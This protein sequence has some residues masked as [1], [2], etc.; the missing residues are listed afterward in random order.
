MTMTS[1]EFCGFA[2][3]ALMFAV[4]AWFWLTDLDAKGNGIPLVGTYSG[5]FERYN[6]NSKSGGQRVSARLIINFVTPDG[7]ERSAQLIDLTDL[8]AI[9]DKGAR[10][11]IVWLPDQPGM[12]RSADALAGPI[13]QNAGWLAGIAALIFLAQLADVLGRRNRKA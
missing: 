11:N 7:V 4:A 12:V 1:R 10:L 9:P 13:G 2:T 5:T 8:D 3:A 6:T